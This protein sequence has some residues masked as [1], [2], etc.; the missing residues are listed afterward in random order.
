MADITAKHVAI[1]VDNYFE[2]VEFTKPKQAFEEAGAQVTVISTGKESL[3]GMYHAELGNMF[4]PDLTI[5]DVQFE[6]YD[7][8]MLPGGVIN[9]DAL[10]MNERAR[11]WVR[12]C[13][14]NGVPLAAIC[15]A[16]WLFVSADIVDGMELTSYFTLQDDIRNAGGNW[17]DTPL[18][19]DANVITSRKPDDLPQFCEAAIDMLNRTPAL[20]AA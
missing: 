18:V 12:Y 11:D 20:T 3:R 15:H 5:P 13:I 17:V 16:P 19:V 8:L 10:R 4:M 2:E 7:M 6:D 9:A 14:E 1:L